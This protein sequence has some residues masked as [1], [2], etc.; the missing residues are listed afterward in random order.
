MS[1]LLP[2]GTKVK[3]QDKTKKLVDSPEPLFT[4]K[5]DILINSN[6]KKLIIDTKYK[7]LNPKDRKYGV[8]QADMYQMLAYTIK[9]G[10]NQAVLLYPRHLQAKT[11][12]LPHTIQFNGNEVKVHI[13][14]ILLNVDLQ[15]EKHV[16]LD[17][18][19]PICALIHSC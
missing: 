17:Q 13:K 2:S 15:K 11:P 5:P 1:Q 9:H 7:M 3:S 16:L 10:C 12:P 8:S 6:G 18:L 19:K 4:I 14:T